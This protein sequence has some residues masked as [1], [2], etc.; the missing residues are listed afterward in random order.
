MMVLSS[1]IVMDAPRRWIEVR[2]GAET[3]GSEAPERFNVG[4]DLRWRFKRRGSC[5]RNTRSRRPIAAS[6]SGVEKMK[7]MISSMSDTS[8]HPAYVKISCIFARRGEPQ[9]NRDEG[10]SHRM[11]GKWWTET[12]LLGESTHHVV[13]DFFFILDLLDL[14]SYSKEQA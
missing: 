2:C 1:C 5:L 4:G 12:Q 9:D 6:T 14:G 10:R 3:D 7:T 13:R 11:N 8:P